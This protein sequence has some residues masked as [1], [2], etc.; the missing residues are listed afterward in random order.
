VVG[1]DGTLLIGLLRPV[2][3]DLSVR[4]LSPA[5]PSRLGRLVVASLAD[6]RKPSCG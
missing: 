2:G 5:S 4:S 1:V 3:G 6:A